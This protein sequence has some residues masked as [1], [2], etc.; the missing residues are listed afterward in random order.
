MTESPKHVA[1]VIP[2]LTRAGAERVAETL[3]REFA[4][5]KKVTIV[6]M[7]PRLSTQA[8][9]ELL[10]LPWADRIPAGCR[11]VH[12]PSAGSGL[13]RLAPLVIRFA[14]LARRENFDAV[15]S[16]LTWTNVLVAAARLLGGG[17]RHIA[18]EHAMAKSLRTDGGQLASLSRAL[19]LVYR[20]PDWIVVISN[21]ARRSLLAAG[22][23]PRSERAVTIPNPVDGP[24]IRKLADAPL[25]VVIPSGNAT[26]VVCVARLHVQKD[27]ATLLRALTRLPDHYALVLVG[28]GPLR[29]ELEVLI[30]RLGL[31]A[32]VTLAGML[33]NPYP[34]M[35]RAD[36]I[37]LPSREEGFGLVA[38][39]A[40]ALGVPFVGSEVGGLAEVCAALG[41]RTF[42]PGD[43]ENLAQAI[44]EITSQQG[45][46]RSPADVVDQIYGPAEIAARYL[47]LAK[48]PTLN[49]PEHG[50][51]CRRTRRTPL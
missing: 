22:V 17:Y 47:S 35:R 49:A 16:F 2:S 45:A 11:Q 33:P 46:D 28:D 14:A 9:R 12:L 39:E 5:T 18:S 3:A 8:I 51:R 32:R 15:Y 36:V 44:L 1:V 29:G 23:L 41:L 10:V 48:A 7:E 26:V 37:V 13:S 6:T 40:A 42:T 38:A 31:E 25:D 21:A 27:H 24:E 4:R 30:S 43:D 34:V 20:R 50:R 19:P